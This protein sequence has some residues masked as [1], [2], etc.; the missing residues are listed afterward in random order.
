MPSRLDSQQRVDIIL[1][2]AK[3]ES[4]SAVQKRY[5]EKYDDAAPAARTLLNLVKKFEENGS[6]EDKKRPGK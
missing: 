2:Y 4:I 6:V 1:W 3:F 5:V